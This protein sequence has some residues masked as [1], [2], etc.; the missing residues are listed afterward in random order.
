V[1]NVAVTSVITVN[2]ITIF[3]VHQA[4][5]AFTLEAKDDLNC[6]LFNLF[7]L[8]IVPQARYCVYST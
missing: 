4:H 6:I 8:M 7:Y 2:D 3:I 5:N 1:L